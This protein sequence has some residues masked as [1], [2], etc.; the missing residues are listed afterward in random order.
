[1]LIQNL[2]KDEKLTFRVTGRG[3][4]KSGPLLRAV[5]NSPDLAGENARQK[6]VFTSLVF[7]TPGRSKLSFSELVRKNEFKIELGVNPTVFKLRND[8]KITAK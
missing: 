4:I 7:T 3:E 6:T 1:M 5:K 8:D 2:E